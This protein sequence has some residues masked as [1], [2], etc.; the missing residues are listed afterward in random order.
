MNNRIISK[1]IID[2]RLDIP[3]E[4]QCCQMYQYI[5]F[6][7]LKHVHQMYQQRSKKSVAESQFSTGYFF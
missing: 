6:S 5:V 2:I 4:N 7:D 1:S 3:A